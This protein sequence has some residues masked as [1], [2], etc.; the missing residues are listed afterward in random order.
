MNIH[1]L[2]NPSEALVTFGKLLGIGTETWK[3]QEEL[4]KLT[5]DDPDFD[6]TKA[7]NLT[8]DQIV[9]LINTYGNA[10]MCHFILG[11][12]VVLEI[13]PDI[14]DE[15]LIEFRNQAHH[16][17]TLRF[18]LRLDKSKLIEKLQDELP[19]HCRLFL[20]LFPN[21]L[22]RFLYSELKGL[23]QSLW[24]TETKHKVIILVPEH[25]IWLTGPYLAVLGGEQIENWRNEVPRE[26]LDI[27]K[28]K[29]M[30][31]TCRENLKW[32]ESWLQHLTPLHIKVEG[33]ALPKDLIA[34]ALH[35]HLVNSIILYTA[36]R[37]VGN[38]DKPEFSTYVKATQ[39]VNLTL[40]N[41]K[42]QLKEEER[43]GVRSLLKMLEW[44]Y[45]P[46]W[47]VDRLP[48]VQISVVQA[49][50][51]ADPHVRYRLLMHNAANIFDGLI[52]HWKAF[53]EGRVDAYMSEVR[54][55]ED[56]IGD[57]SQAFADQTEAMIKSLSDTM[58]AAVGVLLG[59]FIAAL[60]QNSFNQ[61][62]FIIGM[63]VYAA[64]VFIFPL[65]YNMSYQW[66]RY[67]TIDKEFKARHHRFEERLHP[68]KVKEI[69][70][71]NITESERSFKSWFIATLLA[72]I[73]VIILAIYAAIKV[74]VVILHVTQ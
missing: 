37:T 47:S 9:P 58:L 24:G 35:V 61:T 19:P 49:L 34:N 21:A 29:K 31:L 11:E 45:E 25:G 17:P 38:T 28:V 23:E 42:D 36:D 1:T 14:N 27:E 22:E 18:E 72:Y 65:V 33:K 71:T 39:S 6:C 44:T 12:L 2:K 56:Y 40:T 50:Y 48:L 55:L 68:D 64:Y 13:T 43:D 41:P 63:A 62:I 16:S 59:S 3:A 73:I 46:Q 20:Y 4:D 54:A 69:V 26:P 30:Y 10:L 60:F 67:K 53:I 70:G 74:P 66:H 7:I 8:L 5:Y 32:Q 52:W 51:V 15:K 57:T